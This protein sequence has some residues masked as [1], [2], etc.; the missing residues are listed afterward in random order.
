VAPRTR[1]RQP[2]QIDTSNDDALERGNA[3]GRA[4]RE[5]LMVLG[6][7]LFAERGIEGVSLREIG[8]EAGQRNNNVIQYHFGDRDGL[9]GAIYAFR[10]EQL[11]IRRF[12][13]IDEYE[14][15]HSEDDP[16]SL[17]RILLRPHAESLSQPD[18]HFVGFLA[19][20]MLDLGSIANQ[21]AGR[22]GQFT[23]ANDQLRERIRLSSGRVSRADFERRFD[24]LFNFA[25][26]ALA[27]QRRVSAGHEMRPADEILDEI[28]AIMVAGLSAEPADAPGARAR[29]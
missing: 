7:R 15:T 17:I 20:L 21:H 9:V 18:N 10:S 23:Q 27:V 26:T 29:R 22:A 5:L 25:I 11:N 14:A 24:L 16:A 13:L 8:L 28:V 2:Q 4:T 3:T 12:E 19:R 1:R 6:E